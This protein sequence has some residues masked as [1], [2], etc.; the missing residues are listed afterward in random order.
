MEAKRKKSTVDQYP[1]DF[2]GYIPD[3]MQSC[4]ECGG[5]D[6][7]SLRGEPVICWKC[8]GSKQVPVTQEEQW[9]EWFCLEILIGYIPPEPEIEF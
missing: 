9:Q 6:L 7:C 2:P 8:N 4:S 3:L 5:E 1:V